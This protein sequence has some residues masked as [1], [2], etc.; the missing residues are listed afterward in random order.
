MKQTTTKKFK[1]KITGLLIFVLFCFV[2]FLSWGEDCQR[3]KFGDFLALYEQCSPSATHLPCS[4]SCSQCKLLY[5]V[6]FPAHLYVNL[7]G[8]GLLSKLIM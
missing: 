7:T 2:L 1:F 3:H 6:C 8:K 4:F 5:C